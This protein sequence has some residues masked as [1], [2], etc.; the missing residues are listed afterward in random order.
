MSLTEQGYIGS[1]ELL[2]D[3]QPVEGN[4]VGVGADTYYFGTPPG[5]EI[6]VAIGADIAGSRTNLITAINTSGTANVA[7]SIR[8][9]HIRIENADAPGG[10][11]QV[12]TPPDTPLSASLAAA[13]NRWNAANLSELGEAYTKKVT[14]QRTLSVQNLA[15]NEYRIALGITPGRGEVRIR[16]ALLRRERYWPVVFDGQ[17][18]VIQ[19]QPANRRALAPGTVVRW[20]VYGD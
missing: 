6:A 1:A 10:T 13:S 16:R 11:P 7:A 12:G 8:N 5:S 17:D 18:L 4:T 20:V 14:G 2:L 19:K 3:T 9:A 15:G